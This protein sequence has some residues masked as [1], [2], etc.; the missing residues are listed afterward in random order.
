MVYVFLYLLNV[1]LLLDLIIFKFNKPL[2]TISG[3]YSHILL[4]ISAHLFGFISLYIWIYFFRWSCYSR[5]RM[6]SWLLLFENKTYIVIFT[7]NLIV[8]MKY[9]WLVSGFSLDPDNDPLCA[10]FLID[11][12]AIR[13]TDYEFLIRLHDEWEVCDFMYSGI[14]EI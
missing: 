8:D 4:Y 1:V 11:Y 6:N 3:M 9:L 10:I 13:A 7:R 2:K 14:S 12:Y 5:E